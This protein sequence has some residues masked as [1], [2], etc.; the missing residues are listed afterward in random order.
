MKAKATALM[1]VDLGAVRSHSRT[2]TSNDNPFSEDHFRTLKYQPEFPKRF[3]TI[4]EARTFGR[5]FFAWYNEDHHH[6]GIGLI[7]PDQIHFGQA[8]TIHASKQRLMLRS[9]AHPGGSS[10]N[11]R[12]H[13]KSRQ[14][15]GSIRQSKRSQPKPNSKPKCF[16][17]VDTFRSVC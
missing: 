4:D 2:Y 5:R 12:N 6:A 9:Q 7:T 17:V 11:A 10:A 15:S 13:P 14:M 3:E 16:K 1:P 8:D